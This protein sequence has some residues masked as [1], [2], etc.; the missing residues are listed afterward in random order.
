MWNWQLVG[1]KTVKRFLEEIMPHI[2]V[3]RLQAELLY[4][5]CNECKAPYRRALGLSLD[6]L[7]W[8]EGVY[9]DL[10]ALNRGEAPATTKRE[11]PA[12]GCDSLNF[13]VSG[14]GLVEVP[15][16]LVQ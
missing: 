1:N 4:M 11:N 2:V 15:D 12:R 14:R 9:E 10:K 8:R 16:P 5:F 13:R 7:N 6:E 3:K